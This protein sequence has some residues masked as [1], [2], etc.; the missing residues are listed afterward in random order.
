MALQPLNTELQDYS[1]ILV[2]KSKTSK[3]QLLE[4]STWKLNKYLNLQVVKLYYTKIIVDFYKKLHK[5]RS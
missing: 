1:S 2:K 5:I 3:Y 4:I